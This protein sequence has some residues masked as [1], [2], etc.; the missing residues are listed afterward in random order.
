[1]LC[2]GRIRLL[3]RLQITPHRWH[4][5]I[6]LNFS[7]LLLFQHWKTALLQ[8]LLFSNFL[9][10]RCKK[11]IEFFIL[12]IDFTKSACFSTCIFIFS[13]LSNLFDEF[14][15]ERFPIW[16]IFNSGQCF[17]SFYDLVQILLFSMFIWFTCGAMM[18]KIRFIWDACFFPYSFHWIKFSS[19]FSF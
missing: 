3:F 9:L 1:M 2:L 15:I 5:Y 12:K 19:K 11:I 16:P 13:F 14:S 8:H 6:C 17:I 4:R 10:R 7:F 18:F